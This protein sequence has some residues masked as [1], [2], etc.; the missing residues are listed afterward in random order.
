M[1]A[2]RDVNLA[3]RDQL[4]ELERIGELIAGEGP[5]L[6][7]EYEP[8]GVRH[9]L[10]ESDAEGISELRRRLIPLRDGRGCRRAAG[11]TPTGSTPPRSADYRTLVLRR[12]PVQSRPPAPYRLLWS[13]DSYEVWQR[14]ADESA[15]RASIP[16]GSAGDPYGE[17]R[18]ARV[19][20]LAQ[21]GGLVAAAGPRPV[22]VP[23]AGAEY[24]SSWAVAG[25]PK[26]PI[27]DGAGTLSARVSL[28]RS[29][30]YEVWLGGSVRP[31]VEL[32]VDG[33]PA[34]EVRHELNNQ[35]QFVRL[36]AAQLEPGEHELAIRFGGADLHPGSGGVGGPIGPLILAAGDASSE[37]LVRVAAGDAQRLCGR[38]WDWIQLR[39]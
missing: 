34:G 28:S 37:R 5:T 32:E 2:Y 21:R 3:P 27:P 31:E 35:G 7:T 6:M 19:R 20:A 24:P 14:P 22:A 18:C 39:G 30:D 9:F 26:T 15:P 12:S 11:P 1:L 8:Y 4:A 10:R 17:P 13:G 25:S 36:G 23:L 38:A 16:L 29:G 33:E